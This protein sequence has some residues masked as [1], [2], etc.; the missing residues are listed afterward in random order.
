MDKEEILWLIVLFFV[1]ALMNWVSIWLGIGE[2]ES[3]TKWLGIILKALIEAII[4]W[5]IIQYL[6][7]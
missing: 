1:F 5:A 6:R 7:R 2:Q 3:I 4:V